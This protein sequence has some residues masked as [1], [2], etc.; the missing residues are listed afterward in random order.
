M[1]GWAPKVAFEQ[2]VVET[3]DYFLKGAVERSGAAA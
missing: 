1:L 3:L 2:S